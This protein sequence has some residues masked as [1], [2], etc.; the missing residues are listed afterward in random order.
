[1]VRDVERRHTLDRHDGVNVLLRAF[2]ALALATKWVG[3]VTPQRHH[4]R[5]PDVWQDSLAT[6]CDASYDFT[7][8]ISLRGLGPTPVQG[9]GAG[10]EAEA[11]VRSGERS[12]G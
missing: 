6:C 4:V 1:V 7:A 3:R 11:S 8:H 12:A 2:I 9:C 10:A 5:G